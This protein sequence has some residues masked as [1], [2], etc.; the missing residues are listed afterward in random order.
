MAE[1]V[2][3]QD[4]IDEIYVERYGAIDGSGPQEEAEKTVDDSDAADDEYPDIESFRRNLRKKY[5]F[6]AR[7]VVLRDKNDFKQKH[8]NM[9]PAVEAP[10]V[11]ALLDAATDKDEDHELIREWFNG[12]I[13]TNDSEEALL[14]FPC[15][16]FVIMTPNMRGEV[17]D[18]V[19]DEWI[20][21]VRAVINYDSADITLKMK[22]RLEDFRASSLALNSSVRVGDM[23]TTFEDGHSEYIHQAK[24]RKIDIKGK[25]IEEILDSAY[26][27]QDYLQILSQVLD[28]FDRDATAKALD[29]IKA[30]V[31]FADVSGADK[32]DVAVGEETLASEYIIKYQRIYE[33][34]KDH[35]DA[36]RS[37]EK[38][39][40]R[41][42][43][44][45]FFK[46]HDR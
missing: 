4:V 10:I 32:A 42:G 13:D 1:Y 9:I 17:D 31:R 39:T 34:L 35:P 28:V 3:L 2:K 33:Y 21:T 6:L 12:K 16:K 29:G 15:L 27:Q 40:G 30:F 37:V 25:T 22:R 24:E 18:V 23:Y 11:R 36:L 46:M 43:V 5:D 41:S 26:T 19:T 8:S 44:L 7:K 45:D 20:N 38:E 14:L